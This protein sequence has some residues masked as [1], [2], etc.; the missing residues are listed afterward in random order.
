MPTLE[1]ITAVATALY[2]PPPVMVT[3]GGGYSAVATAVIDSRVGTLRT[4]FY[5]VNANRQIINSNVGEINYDT[6]KI[7]LN[8][9][10]II[11]VSAGDGLLRL[12]AVSEEGVIES[13]RNVIITIDEAD[14]AAIVTTLEKI[15]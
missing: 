6:G 12:T 1:S 10:N 11:S 14:T 9:L 13:T 4:I 5:D 2:P 15:A 7:T 8:D 3:V